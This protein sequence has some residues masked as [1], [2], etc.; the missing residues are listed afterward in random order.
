[1]DTGAAFSNEGNLRRKIFPLSQ[2]TTSIATQLERSF[3]GSYWI[4]AEVSKLNHYPQSGHCF[5]QLVEKRDGKIVAEIRAFILNTRYR[6]IDRNFLSVSG[7]PLN[8]GMQILFRCKV[9]YHAVYGL[10]LSIIEV[11]PGYTLGE[12]ARMRHEAMARLRK[13]GILNQNKSLQL[14]LLLRKLAVISVETS[15]GWRD[16]RNTLDESPYGHCIHTQL[17]PAL[18]Q[19]DA[20]VESIGKALRTIAVAPTQFD[21]VC[22]IRGGGGEVGMDCYDQYTMA[23]AVCTYPLPVLSGIGHATNLTL[24]EQVAYRNLITPTALAGFVMEGFE[25]Y[26]NRIAQATVGLFNMKRSMLRNHIL[27]LERDTEALHLSAKVRIANEGNALQASVRHFEA[28]ANRAVSKHSSDVEF[29]YPARLSEASRT[30]VRNAKQRLKRLPE[31]MSHGARALE[32]NRSQQL[33]LI[34]EKVRLLDPEHTLKRGYSIT[35]LEG[36][37][38]TDA[39]ALNPGDIVKTTFAS[40]SAES[41]I[42]NTKP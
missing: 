41:T 17:F 24:V 18:L 30:I 19:G 1:M 6:E 22:I 10:S 26:E 28:S 25:K 4:T 27:L 31:Q 42:K 11:E 20:A 23:A 9:S 16:F 12:M 32:K 14:P 37:P 2:L 34:S 36:K 38:V 35:T 13:E 21:A 29:R 3:D 5:P 15:K 40:G 39:G 33:A 7:K 8:E